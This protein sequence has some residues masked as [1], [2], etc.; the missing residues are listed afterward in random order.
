MKRCPR[1]REGKRAR[2][3]LDHEL[4]TA[5]AIPDRVVATRL[6]PLHDGHPLVIVAEERQVEVGAAAVG[7]GADGELAQQPAHCLGVPSVLG[8]YN[9]VF[10][11]EIVIKAV[12][13][14]TQI[15]KLTDT[16]LKTIH[17]VNRSLD[18]D[19]SQ[20]SRIA[21]AWL[22]S[23]TLTKQK[24]ESE[25][26]NINLEKLFF[27][28]KDATNKFK[29]R[30]AAQSVWSVSGCWS[31]I[32]ELP[33]PIILGILPAALHCQTAPFLCMCWQNTS[34]RCFLRKGAREVII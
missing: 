20:N 13:V 14:D 12:F 29:M 32:L 10:K 8:V 5:D 28:K 27:F 31:V 3:A 19:R 9:S 16:C 23:N 24:T 21:P 33:F 18:I 15:F 6:G 4:V 11:P 17:S 25:M 26:G 22:A 2:P 30:T 34:S 7:L 1:R